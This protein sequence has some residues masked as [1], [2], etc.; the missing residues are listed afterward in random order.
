MGRTFFIALLSV[1]L[2]CWRLAGG[3]VAAGD[4]PRQP[5]RSPLAPRDALAHFRLPDGLGIELVAAE[6]QVVDPVAMA[7]D[8]QGRLWVAEM[9]DYPHGPKPGEQPGSTI[10]LLEDRDGDG[11]FE[12]AHLFAEK[13]LF[14][15]GVLPWKNGVIATL[16]GEIVFLADT[17]GDHRADLRETWF[18]GFS[19][20]N[21]QLRANHP[22]FGPDNKIYVANG[23]RGGTI[24][25]EVKK[26]GA[27]V[28][29]VS[30]QGRDFRFDPIT[31]ACEA[32]SGHGQYGLTFDDWGDRFVCSNR[33]PCRQVL[34]EERYL[35][36]NPFLAVRD[37]CH[38]VSPPAELSRV[39]PLSRAWTTSTLHAGQFT[40]ACGVTIFR[41][42]QLPEEFYGNAFVCEP[43]GNLVHCDRL[44]SS[45]AQEVLT[46]E[47]KQLALRGSSYT[48][49][50]AYRESEFL[51]TADE[52]FRPVD[53]AN[54]PDGALY[55]VDMYRAV[56]EHPEWVPSELKTRA[57]QLLGN[58]RGRIY[59]V[60]SAM[61]EERA[62]T[63]PV[64]EGTTA[65][66]V[67]RLAGGN[68]AVRDLAAQALFERQDK[69]AGTAL[70]E[71]ALRGERAASRVAALGVL[72]GLGLLSD[73]IVFE[74]LKS[75]GPTRT[76]ALQLLEGR[77]NGGRLKASPELQQTALELLVSALRA[78]P[79][80]FAP[81]RSTLQLALTLGEFDPKPQVF[82]LLAEL[83]TP[84][85][86]ASDEWLVQAVLCSAGDRPHLLLR[87]VL[88]HREFSGNWAQQ[89]LI[90][91]I[92]EVIGARRQEEEL[93]P[94]LAALVSLPELGN[95]A[96]KRRST[97]VMLAG[98]AGLGTGLA[99]RGESLFATLDKLE[100]GQEG[101]RD[102]VAP[103]FAAAAELAR[104]SAS[105]MELRGLALS[106]LQHGA[107][108]QVQRP[109]IEL[110]RGD[111]PQGIRVRAIQ[112]LAAFDR[113]EI[114]PALLEDFS[115]QTPAIRRVVLQ[116]LLR[117]LGRTRLLLDEVAAGRMALSEL[118]PLEIAALVGHKDVETK[119]RA[120][121]LLA[122]A[123]PADRRQ[124][125]D[126]YRQSLALKADPRKGREL[127]DKNCATC[128]RVA[129]IGVDVAPDIAD[130]RTKT[131][132]QLLADI[133]APN[134]AIDA[135]YVSYTIATRDGRSHTGVIAAETAASVTLKQPEGKT[136]SILR[137]DIDE[138]VS[139]G[140]S[141]MPEGLE[142]NITVAQMA[143]LIS[144]LK[145]WR[146]L[147]GSIPLAE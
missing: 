115:H 80:D 116:A 131:P 15:T 95:A 37:V 51:A 128:H 36:R 71:L 39:F 84:G 136:V 63:R 143:D 112:A 50:S 82:S 127:F 129:G 25:P 8:G 126:T 86:H 78:N 140:V 61:I 124:V 142:K 31:G 35:R 43:T 42:M 79:R 57:D 19:Q 104:D 96:Q 97:V 23:L 3:S 16:S 11:Q 10:R 12:T 92:C 100:A 7:F 119:E 40:A 117:D 14:V 55:I 2:G 109:L 13:L 102:A 81:S 75:Q 107:F 118:G 17:D 135:N 111:E 28:S 66:I 77:L 22:R 6:P 134:Q 101:V 139:S 27:G 138:L 34:L 144:F 56:I 98:V 106:C 48:G 29:P 83:V 58:D 70:I 4:E 18:T 132:E 69:T 47:G 89:Q 32:V 99:R 113:A 105:N 46:T 121:K 137:Q 62:A 93:L 72:D 73:E 108:D 30:I 88:S 94:T 76:R 26:W 110:A 74:C 103:V 67:E 114:G 52:W 33:N 60:R 44:E 120:K 9:R 90:R 146:Y 85:V 49:V 54:G 59:R 87:D 147:D 41:G 122:A 130:S 133:L 123:I 20:E 125:L 1:C 5:V 21:S 64:A 141:L 91:A 145:N 53:L 38:D 65:Q 45:T 68:G 24:V